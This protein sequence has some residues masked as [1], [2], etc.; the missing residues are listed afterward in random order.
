[1]HIKVVLS[2]TNVC[3]E[4]AE[5]NRVSFSPMTTSRP[6]SLNKFFMPLKEI[7]SGLNRAK[8]KS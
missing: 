7:T 2:E 6:E 8:E 3:N 4:R 5:V 1:M